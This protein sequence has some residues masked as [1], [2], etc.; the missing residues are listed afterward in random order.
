[1]RAA[2]EWNLDDTADF[3][4][5]ADVNVEVDAGA[6]EDDDNFES[7]IIDNVPFP[8]IASRRIRAMDAA[9]RAQWDADRF[10]AR[11]DQLFLAREILGLDLVENP[12]RVL[13]GTFLV[14]RPGVP[15]ANLDTVK[16]RLI[17]WPRGHAKTICSR[18]EMVSIL[19]SYPNARICFLTGG[20]SLAK[21]QLRAL[22]EIFEKPK[23]RFLE[24]FP[25]YC[26]TS[27]QN[28]KNLVWSD[29]L[30]EMGTQHEFT[31]PCKESTASAEPTFMISTTKMVKAG[32]HFDFIFC[33]DLVNETNYRS[34]TALN[35]CYEDFLSLIP[36]L[37]PTGYITVTGTRYSF[38]D[39]Y[40]LIIEQAKLA[41]EASLWRFSIRDCWSTSCKNCSHPDVYHNRDVNPLQPPCGLAGAC[42]CPGF[43]SDGDTSGVL[44]PQITKRDGNLWGFSKA[45]LESIR[46]EMGPQLFS[47]QYENNVLAADTQTFT[48]NMIRAQTLNDPKEIPNYFNCSLSFVCGDLADSDSASGD[49]DMSVLYLCRKSQGRIFLVNAFFGR[50]GSAELVSNIIRCLTDPQWRPSIIYLEKTLGSG[51]LNDL[52]MARANQLGLPKVNIS[53]LK[54]GNHRGS[55]ALRI[56]NLQEALTSKRL[57]ISAG[58]PGYQ[59]LLEQMVRWPRTKH[60][61]FVDCA[62]RAME[63]PTGYPPQS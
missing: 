17:L 19:L 45:I 42:N 47:N 40:G 58:L 4:T 22:K 61:D 11:T 31:L 49:R 26:L 50:W 6:D 14:K 5:Q 29:S 55:K 20:D 13:F 53:W 9:T 57:F 62:A 33:D 41:R 32:L 59:Q 38:G 25:E 12:H 24:L 21:I 34:A 27:H 43:V 60:D 39:S 3:D 10:R 18:V 52:I 23:P 15:M 51:H 36:L 16:R 7:E 1:M 54:T 2:A 28:K 35:K 63:C 44:F 56:S 37:E 48:E 30:D 46:A 8:R